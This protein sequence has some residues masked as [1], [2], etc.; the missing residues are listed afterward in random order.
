[1]NVEQKMAWGWGFD[2]GNYAAAYTLDPDQQTFGH[3]AHNWQ[4][5]ADAEIVTATRPAVMQ[6]PELWR[7]GFLAG[8]YSS[9]ELHEVPDIDREAVMMARRMQAR[10]ERDGQED[11]ESEAAE[12]ST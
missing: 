3:D 6:H 4:T 1:M 9:C 5:L 7:Q 10:M 2:A 12:G 11:D 8:Y